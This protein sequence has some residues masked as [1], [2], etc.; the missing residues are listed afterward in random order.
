M[1]PLAAGFVAYSR[2]KLTDYHAQIVRCVG[3]LTPAGVW[4]RSNDHSNSVGNLLLHLRGNVLMWI[5]AGLGGRAFE[6]DR[7]A[8]FAQREAL[9]VGPVMQRLADAVRDAN[10]VIAGLADD[11]LT[12]SYE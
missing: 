2:L 5:V 1:Q 8:E 3:L 4:Q 12:R 6:R 10:A 7:P 9:P 11:A